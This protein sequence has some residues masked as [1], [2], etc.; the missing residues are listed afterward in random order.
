MYKRKLFNNNYIR[1]LHRVYF[2]F[3][4]LQN[5]FLNTK[6]KNDYSYVFIDR[7]DTIDSLNNQLLP[8]LESIKGF[9]IAAQKKGY[10]YNIKPGKYKIEKGMGNNKII[11]ILRT[12][13]LTVKVTFNNQERLKDL[14]GRVSSQIEADSLDLLNSF[15]N[16]SFLEELDS[17]KKMQCRCTFQIPM[18]FIGIFH[19][20][21]LEKC[22]IIINHLNKKEIKPCQ[23][24]KI[25]PKRSLHLSFHCPKRVNKK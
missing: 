2:H 24:N 6:F 18:K 9:N 17:L 5:I 20:M 1:D 8:L 21:I 7:D 19:L 10:T 14:A 23:I 4:I 11:N 16:I 15:E 3:P 13:R 25:R 22:K 12:K